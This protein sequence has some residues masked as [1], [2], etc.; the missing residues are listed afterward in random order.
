MGTWLTPPNIYILVRMWL[1]T[2]AHNICLSCKQASR[3]SNKLKQYTLFS[4]ILAYTKSQ[5]ANKCHPTVF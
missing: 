4:H 2:V 1:T 3:S 5:S